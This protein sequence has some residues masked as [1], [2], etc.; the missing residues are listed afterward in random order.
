MLQTEELKE[1]YYKAV[2]LGKKTLHVAWVPLVVYL[3][4][5]YSVPRPP[6]HRLLNPLS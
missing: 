5:M 1:L 6:L 2:E 3:G 4:Y